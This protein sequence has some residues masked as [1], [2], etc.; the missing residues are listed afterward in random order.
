VP[1]ALPDP[2]AQL[3]A[4]GLRVTGPRVSTLLTLAEHPHTDAETLAVLVRDRLGAVSTQ[5]VYDVL[6]A[7]TTAGLV[8]RIEPAGSPARYET[9]VDDNHHHAVCRTCGSMRDV[10]CATGTAPCLDASDDHGFVLTEAEVI[11]WGTCPDCQTSPAPQT[12][13][14]QQPTTEAA[15]R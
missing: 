14:D 11:Y 2:G 15:P 5:A 8:R 3:R 10:D 7:L 6:R 1:D 12:S 9:R 4:A 13:P